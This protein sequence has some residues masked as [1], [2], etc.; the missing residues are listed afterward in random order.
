MNGIRGAR[1]DPETFGEK[2]QKEANKFV[3]NESM[4]TFKLDQ[5]VAAKGDGIAVPAI[6]V[7]KRGNRELR[8][9]E[10]SCLLQGILTL[11]FKR[12]KSSSNYSYYLIM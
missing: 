1:K 7:W 10:E 6:E 3:R 2:E 9:R 8:E 4:D 12:N 11:V 5:K